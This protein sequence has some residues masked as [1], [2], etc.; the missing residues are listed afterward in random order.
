M[1]IFI[2]NVVALIAA[3]V[4]I[5]TGIL[6]DKKKI[7]FYQIINMLLYAISNIILGGII[8]FINNLL[9]IIRNILCYKDK[10]GI[11]EKC[12]IT[13]VT[14]LITIKFNNLNFIGILPSISTILYLWFMDTKDIKKFKV[15]IIFVMLFWCIYDFVIKSYVSSLFDFMSVIVNFYSLVKISKQIVKE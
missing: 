14:M 6:T 13:L 2:G 4:L 9:S 1:N 3:L 10:L 5:Y 15:L 11:K 7:I 8:G 12:I